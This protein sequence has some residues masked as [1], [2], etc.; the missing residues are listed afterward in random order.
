MGDRPRS[1]LGCMSEDKVRTKDSC[2]SVGTLYDSKELPGVSTGGP[3]IGRGVTSGIKADPRGFTG[4]CGLGGSGI[5]CMAH[6]GPEWLH[7]MAYDNTRYTDMAKRGGS[8]IGVDRRGR[9]SSKG[10]GL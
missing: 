1:F 7:G 5:W 2:W 9:R 10:G 3:G 6:V 8:W 4:V